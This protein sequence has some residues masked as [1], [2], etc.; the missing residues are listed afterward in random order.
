MLS[1]EEKVST[2]D[3]GSV[4]R[5]RRRW[6]EAQKRRIVAETQEPEVSKVFADGGYGGPKLRDALARRVYRS[7][8]RSSKSPGRSRRS[9]FST[10]AGSWNGRSPGWVGAGA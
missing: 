6:S 9:P 3:G 10:G 1:S 7:S 4:G 8:S 2:A 5:H